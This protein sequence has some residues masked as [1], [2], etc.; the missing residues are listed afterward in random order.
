PGITAHAELPARHRLRE[1]GED[2]LAL[3]FSGHDADADHDGEENAGHLHRPQPH[4]EDDA[5]PVAD[6]ELRDQQRPGDEEGREQQQVVEELAA[7]Q[8]ADGVPGDGEDG[9]HQRISNLVSRPNARRRSPAVDRAVPSASRTYR[10]PWGSRGVSGR[11]PAATSACTER[12][13]T[14]FSSR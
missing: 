6:G 13:S 14:P 11:K 4:V 10:P 3:Y 2:R 8:L 7:D 12:G 1:R 9:A 5:H